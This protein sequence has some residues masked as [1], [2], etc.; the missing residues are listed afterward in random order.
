MNNHSL[1]IVCVFLCVCYSHRED[2]IHGIF[3]RYLHN[4]DC[5]AWFCLGTVKHLLFNA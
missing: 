5:K 2:I 1:E 3:I 4:D